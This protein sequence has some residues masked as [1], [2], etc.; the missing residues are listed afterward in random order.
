MFIALLITGAYKDLNII[1][2]S[3]FSW[4]Q[5]GGHFICSSYVFFKLT[6]FIQGRCVG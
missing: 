1:S 6:H 4:E 2:L 3:G 5:S